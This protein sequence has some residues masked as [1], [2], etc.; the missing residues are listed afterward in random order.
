MSQS[1]GNYTK[2]HKT[3]KEQEVGKKFQYKSVKLPKK[4][5]KK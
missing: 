2:L 4:E 5:I 3:L 1:K